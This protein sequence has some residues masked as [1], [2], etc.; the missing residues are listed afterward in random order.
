MV[1]EAGGT[2]DDG[3]ESETGCEVTMLFRTPVEY[4]ANVSLY[5]ISCD[6]V[7]LTLLGTRPTCVYVGENIN[8]RLT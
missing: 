5:T 8:A 2:D 3:M 7:T 1:A 4:V 6:R